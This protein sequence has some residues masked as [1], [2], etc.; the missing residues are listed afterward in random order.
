MK[1]G[2]LV[3]YLLDENNEKLMDIHLD[4]IEQHTKMPFTI[5]AATNRLLPKFLPKLQN[6]PNVKICDIET[7]ELRGHDEH[8]YYLKNLADYA[9][10]D[11]AD[12]L[13]IL[14]LDSFPVENA[15]DQ[16]LAK[17]LTGKTVLAAIIIILVAFMTTWF[18]ILAVPP[19]KKKVFPEKGISHYGRN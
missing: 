2:I 9:I 14:H 12:Y 19:K 18:F 11:E 6:N 17:K 3:I 5:Y 16:K 10:E 8:S 15:W 1:I 13:A 7:T 4:R